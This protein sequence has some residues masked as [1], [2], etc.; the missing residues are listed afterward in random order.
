MTPDVSEHL[1]L[2]LLQCRAAVSLRYKWAASL[3][4]QVLAGVLND[5]EIDFDQAPG[6]EDQRANL[7]MD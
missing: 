4:R 3:A 6:S 5:L 7:K 2:R 1:R